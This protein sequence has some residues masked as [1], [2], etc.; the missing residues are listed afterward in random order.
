MM[1]IRV[2][3]GQSDGSGGRAKTVSHEE[4]PAGGIDVQIKLLATVAVTEGNDAIAHAI[5]Q[6]LLDPCF[7]SKF[8]IA[9]GG[10]GKIEIA[11]NIARIIVIGIL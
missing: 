3:G 1:P 2:N 6:K 11:G 7:H 5:I 9:A 4:A 8:H 10:G